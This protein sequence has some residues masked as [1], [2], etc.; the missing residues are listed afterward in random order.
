MIRK[1]IVAIVSLLLWS[2]MAF[3][4]VDA[5]TA[6]KEELDALKGVGPKIAQRIVDERQKNGPYKSLD[7]LQERV[8]GVG[9]ANVKK[10]A[11][12]GLTVGDSSTVSSTAKA[13]APADKASAAAA[14]TKTTAKADKAS[15][16]DK[17]AAAEPASAASGGKSRKKKDK[18]SAA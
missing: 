11:A 16:A 1:L 3:A 9:P 7:D 10:L 6:T 12:E 4:A 13:K 15:K 14:S 8:K 17:A 5:N 2:T 18:A